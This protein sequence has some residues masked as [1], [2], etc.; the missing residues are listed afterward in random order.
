M[1]ATS[2][3]NSNAVKSL[4]QGSELTNILNVIRVDGGSTGQFSS[5]QAVIEDLTKF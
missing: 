3:A 5:A 4:A 2:Q 1:N